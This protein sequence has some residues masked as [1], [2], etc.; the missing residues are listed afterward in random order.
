ME[1]STVEDKSC[2]DIQMPTLWRTHFDINIVY[3]SSFATAN[4]DHSSMYVI[5]LVDV[6]SH[7]ASIYASIPTHPVSV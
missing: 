1:K 6:R 4:I 2:W 7:H 3:V 5:D